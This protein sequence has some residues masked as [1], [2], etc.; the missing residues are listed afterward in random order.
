[1]RTATVCLVVF[2]AAC[3]DDSASSPVA[4][5]N[6]MA[7]TTSGFTLSGTVRDSRPN[8]PALAGA[9][10]RLDTGQSTAAG[11]DGRYRFQHVS[12]AVTVT[13]SGPHHAAA[14]ETA[15]MD[16]DRTVDFALAHTGIPPFEGTVFI[17]PRLIDSSDSTSL[18]NVTYAG[19]GMREVFDRRVDRWIKVDAYLFDV[20]YGWGAVEFQ[21]NPEFGSVDAARAEVDTY[22]PALGRLP[23]FL[24]TNAREVEINDGVELFGGNPNGSFLIHTGQGQRYIDDGFLE[25]IL[26]HEAAHVSLDA[27]HANAPGWT[28]AQTADGVF[29]STYARD[30]PGRE[31]VAESILPYFAV[32]R[33]S[34]RLGDADRTAILAAIPN[35]LEYFDRQG[36]AN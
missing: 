22:A 8:G 4:P 35:R 18:M 30:N 34:A 28:T 33:R 19:Q 1:M 14:S 24:M 23:A 15:T 21:V 6:P 12:G 2:A 31:D 29:V 36:F 32:R 13:A 17:S 20:R 9:T 11:S 26:F 3:S 10:I 25:E 16:Q 27:R 5:T 7:P